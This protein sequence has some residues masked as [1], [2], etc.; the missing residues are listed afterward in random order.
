VSG[1][2]REFVEAVEGLVRRRAGLVFSEARRPALEAS[3]GRALAALPN[4]GQDDFLA[5][6]EADPA[7]PDDLVAEITV[8]ESYFFRDTN[9][10]HLIR[11]RVL[12]ELAAG[13]RDRPLRLWS[14]G[15]DGRK[16]IPRIRIA[17]SA[18]SS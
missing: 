11:E 7:L 2:R 16:F 9:Q 18:T 14:A 10:F 8:G 4:D 1:L 15:C 12:P 17:I 6:L 5:R 3:L 13:D